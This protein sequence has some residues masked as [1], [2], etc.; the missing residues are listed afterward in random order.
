M[1]TPALSPTPAYT[2]LAP[3]VQCV[4]DGAAGHAPNYPPAPA[5]KGYGLN[6]KLAAY[7]ALADAAAKAAALAPG[8]DAHG[9]ERAYLPTGP[10]VGPHPGMRAVPGS[11]KYDLG[12]EPTLPV[13]MPAAND[14]WWEELVAQYSS[15]PE[16]SYVLRPANAGLC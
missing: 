13:P 11:A 12:I 4:Q 1:T 10:G 7:G 2:R 15:A 6:P 3:C 5:H 14:R 9:Y 16:Q 8:L